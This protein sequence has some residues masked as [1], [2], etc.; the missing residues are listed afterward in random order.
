MAPEI[1]ENEGYGLKA[2]IW[3]L[4][5][6]I[7]DMVDQECAKHVRELGSLYGVKEV[8]QRALD[9]RIDCVGNL[10][11][12]KNNERS[13]DGLLADLIK[14]M[15]RIDKDERISIVE[16]FEDPWML[17]MAEGFKIKFSKYRAKFNKTSVQTTP[18]RTRRKSK[19]RID[20]DRLRYFQ[21]GADGLN[22]GNLSPHRERDSSRDKGFSND[23]GTVRGAKQLNK[24]VSDHR[25]TSNSKPKK[26]GKKS[27]P[28]FKRNGKNPSTIKLGDE[29]IHQNQQLSSSLF[30]GDKNRNFDENSSKPYDITVS[31]FSSSQQFRDSPARKTVKR[32]KPRQYTREPDQGSMPQSK[33]DEN[34]RNRSRGKRAS[35]KP[36][37]SRSK[38]FK[39]NSASAKTL[40]GMRFNSGYRSSRADPQK[41]Q[42]V[43]LSNTARMR[44]KKKRERE[45][46]KKEESLRQFIDKFEDTFSSGEED[47]QDEAEI[48]QGA[49]RGMGW[50]KQSQGIT[51]EEAQTE[52]GFYPNQARKGHH[53]KKASINSLQIDSRARNSRQRSRR[54]QNRRKSTTV[55]ILEEERKTKK[56]FKF[57]G[58]ESQPQGLN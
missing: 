43:Q 26:S 34:L 25:R 3:A 6:L 58:K 18:G 50:Y 16:V 32:V 1:I 30:F 33:H 23:P 55:A 56:I 27:T 46:M 39:K 44:L 53:Q 17:K 28:S 47:N 13:E 2:D 40:T 36:P 7:L 48:V 4:G 38:Q 12:E 49:H 10:K 20:S 42:S 35:E 19:M 5:L 9:R 45:E 21:S 37:L 22:E 24:R 51:Q 31:D 57:Y 14:K 15:L 11:Q 29:N 52:Y 41:R 8:S 54:M